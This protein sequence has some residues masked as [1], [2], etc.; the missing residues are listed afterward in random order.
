LKNR[1]ERAKKRKAELDHLIEG[2]FTDDRAREYETLDDMLD[3]FRDGTLKPADVNMLR[4]HS[5][6]WA[7]KAKHGGTQSWY[8]LVSPEGISE[9]VVWHMVGP[10]GA[11][12]Y[13]SWSLRDSVFEEAMAPFF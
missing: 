10:K 5:D 8:V 13:K 4:V 1:T 3:A 12:G 9:F 6:D 11:Q 7:R 2:Y